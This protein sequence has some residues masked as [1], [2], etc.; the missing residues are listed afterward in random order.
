M[1]VG[2]GDACLDAVRADCAFEAVEI[3]A[4]LRVRGD[5]NDLHAQRGGCAEDAEI[6]GALDR[7]HVA[8]FSHGAQAQIYG[9]ESAACDH[10]V[11]G[12]EAA[13]SVRRPARDLSPQGVDARRKLVIRT[14]QGL[15][16]D[17]AAHDQI[18]GA[19]GKQL[20]AGAAR[21]E[22]DA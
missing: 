2:H 14:V 6:G 21:G 22:R 11:F 8:R 3:H 13:A 5:L 4:L 9:L 15:A 20:G 10:D 19:I 18:H 7:D 1:A 17:D 16:V 12:S